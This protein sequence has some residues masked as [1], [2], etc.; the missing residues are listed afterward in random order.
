MCQS[1]YFDRDHRLTMFNIETGWP[2]PRPRGTQRL[3]F[4]IRLRDTRADECVAA[5]LIVTSP[6]GDTWCADDVVDFCLEQ[7]ERYVLLHMPRLCLNEEGLYR[8]ELTLGSC[9]PTAI[10]VMVQGDAGQPV[11]ACVHGLY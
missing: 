6:H 9:E 11:R 5:A 4:V 1:A 8:F 2:V 3:S 10:D 7:H